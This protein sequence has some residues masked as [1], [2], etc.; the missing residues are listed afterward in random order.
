MPNAQSERAFLAMLADFEALD[1][2][3]AEFYARARIDFHA[4]VQSLLDE[5]RGLNLRDGWVP[6]THRWLCARGGEIVGVARLRH[7]IATPFLFKDGGHIGYDVAPSHRG[8][9][10]GHMAL[11]V[12]L[13][14][15]KRQQ[16]DRVLLVT[17]E[18]N[19]ASRA[20]IERQG[21]VLE[22]IGYSEF[23]D[24]QLSRYWI[25]VPTHG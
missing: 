25:N 3:N 1:P 24:E 6:Y 16:L 21:G 4:Y 12:A 2:S 20:V 8:K 14:E 5:E 10:F 9:G 17:G 7:N 22:S 15:A 19:A 13:A 11:R 18:A 23:W